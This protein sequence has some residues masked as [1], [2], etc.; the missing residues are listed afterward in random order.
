MASI[1]LLKRKNGTIGYSADVRL[2]G[3]PSYKKTFETKEEAEEWAELTETSLRTGNLN[4]LMTLNEMFDRYSLEILPNKP[5]HYQS[6]QEPHIKFWRE[7]IG[8][9]LINSITPYEIEVVADTLYMR[10]SKKSGN[11]LTTE[12]RRKYLMTLSYIFNI[13]CIEWKWCYNN[14]VYFVNKHAE[15]KIKSDVV[16]TPKCKEAFCNKIREEMK[17]NRIDSIREL[18]RRMKANYSTLELLLNPYDNSTLYQVEKLCEFF[19]LE[20]VLEF[21]QKPTTQELQRQK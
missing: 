5:K 15:K 6:D 21:R 1:R 7:T 4:S 13:A 12:S 3:H 20:L 19:D 2:K 9:K 10:K 16:K 18:S 14:P 8:S 11:F 17:K